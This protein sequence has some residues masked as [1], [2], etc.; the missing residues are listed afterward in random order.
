MARSLRTSPWT[1]LATTSTPDADPNNP[2]TLYDT[3]LCADRACTQINAGISTYTP[4]YALWSRRREQAPLD[5]HCPPGATI[6]TTD[7]DHWDFPVGTKLWKEFTSTT[8]ATTG[9]R[10]D[11][12]HLALGDGHDERLVLRVVR[13][14]RRAGPTTIAVPAGDPNANGT[15]HDIPARF[16]CKQCHEGISSRVLGFGAIQLDHAAANG[17]IAIDDLDRAAASSRHRRPAARRTIRCPAP[18]ARPPRS[19]TCTRTAATATTRRARST[20][21]RAS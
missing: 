15:Q 14:E 9:A 10:R 5:L 18:A 17:D 20:P 19:A 8:R 4:A 3:G 13:V 21:T 11:A 12:L 7:P 2:P 16:Q 6:D 1:C